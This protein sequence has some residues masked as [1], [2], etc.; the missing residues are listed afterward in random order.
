MNEKEKE[1]KEKIS[2]ILDIEQSIEP[3]NGR[4][5]VVFLN[6]TTDNKDSLLDPTGM[7]KN[8]FLELNNI[9]VR[10]RN[11]STSSG[12]SNEIT[13]P[14]FG[15]KEIIYHELSESDTL[16]ALALTYNCKVYLFSAEN[17]FMNLKVH[18]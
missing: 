4:E 16:Q 11:W 6:S 15:N 14:L 13:K 12:E 9:D 17:P 18:K 10:K 1:Q 2:R 5:A 3:Q 7:S 8:Q